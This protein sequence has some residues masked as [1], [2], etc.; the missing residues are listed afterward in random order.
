MNVHHVKTSTLYT[1]KFLD[2]NRKIKSVG[3]I[4][5]WRLPENNRKLLERRIKTAIAE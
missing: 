2:V 3:S 4:P 5:C 1:A